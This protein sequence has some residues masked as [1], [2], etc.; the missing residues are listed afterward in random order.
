MKHPSPRT[1]AAGSISRRSFLKGIGTVAATAVA[2]GTEAVAAELEQANAERVLGP[3]EVPVS[4]NLNGTR[5]E[6]RAEPRTTLLEVLRTRFGHT[7]AKE[8]CDRGTCGAC[9]V[10]LD[11]K[12]VY[13]CMTLAVA[14]EGASVE[15]IEGQAVNGALSPVQE[16]FIKVDGLQCGF[17]TP[18][19]VMS[20][21]SLLRAHPQPDEAKV[22]AACAGHVCRCGSQPRII[23][24]ALEA[25]GVKTASKAEVVS[26]G[27]HHG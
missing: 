5:V 2:S 7:G 18:G 15:T 17:C 8:G 12:P 25:S 11:G 10:L 21:T 23:A 20:V 27:H 3:G 19:F 6:T 4:F 14:A 24:A 22:R 9:T 16:A 26:W 13:A 1:E